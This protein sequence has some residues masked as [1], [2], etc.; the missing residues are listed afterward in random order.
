MRSL[1]ILLAEDEP[2]HQELL[3]RA[4]TSQR[5]CVDVRVV[6]TGA[7]F[8]KAVHDQRFDC[9]IVDYQLPDTNADDLL[10]A[11]HSDLHGAPAL[12][13]SSNETQQVAVASIRSGSVDFVPKSKA[14]QGNELWDRVRE[15]TRQAHRTT[16]EHQKV[17][18]RQ[19]ELSHLADTDPLTGLLNRRYLDHQLASHAYDR[20][21]R[22]EMSCIMMDLDHFKRINDIRGHA[23]GDMVLQE[24]AALLG[25]SLSGG[26]VAM[27][28]GGEEFVVLQGSTNLAEAWIWAD[29]F[30]NRVA[31]TPFCSEGMD[32]G[33]TVS[34]GVVSFPTAKMGHEMID[35]ADQ[36]MYLA[37]NRGRDR[38]CTWPMV[39]VDQALTEATGGGEFTT[40][41]R[42]RLEFLARCEHILGPTQKE[43]V[44][45]HCLDVEQM[46]ENL[47]GVMGLPQAERCRIQLAGLFHD[48]G[49]SVIPEEL[50]AQPGPLSKAQWAVLCRHPDHSADIS[51]R[52]G[53]D[54]DTV[55]CIRQ[56]HRP[57]RGA[58]IA[59]VAA[60]VICVADAL[61]AM[62]SDRA[63]RSARSAVEALSE[64]RRGAGAQ[65]DPAVV[66]AAHFVLPLFAGKAA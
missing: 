62:M 40:P 30:R 57:W 18:R 59:S 48:V 49:K 44:T 8:E 6:A 31:N 11:L 61:V 39:V 55:A 43:H 25:K 10:R 21:R 27:R 36:A 54:Q 29:E 4:L 14:L 42:Q 24:V 5:P 28:W 50:L 22:R 7:E 52:L 46:A 32:F 47:A 53:I 20:D 66:S 64:L 26:D 60:K 41:A 51:L 56:H 23:A 45:Q 3:V 19:N 35:L 33:V 12:V 15:A 58:S 16:T 63:Y 13:V 65:F 1:K 2:A 9:V 38:V 37:K 34:L 17:E